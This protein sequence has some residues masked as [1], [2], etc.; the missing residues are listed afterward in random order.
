MITGSSSALRF[1]AHSIFYYNNVE[2]YNNESSSNARLV[3]ENQL[4]EQGYKSK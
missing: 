4:F 2:A 3:R 1:V